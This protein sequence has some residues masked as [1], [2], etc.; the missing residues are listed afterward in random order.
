[1]NNKHR[2]SATPDWHFSIPIG[3]INVKFGAEIQLSL[4]YFFFFP[5][6]LPNLWGMLGLGLW[7]A[8]CYEIAWLDHKLR[9]DLPF[10]VRIYHSL[11]CW[12]NQW[13]TAPT[14]IFYSSKSKLLQAFI[15]EFLSVANERTPH[16]LYSISSVLGRIRCRTVKEV[17][18]VGN[19]ASYYLIQGYHPNRL[20]IH[21]LLQIF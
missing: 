11:L 13:F 2:L 18:M 7:S 12:T 6:T 9:Q 19:L 16:F 1:M 4:R 15:L 3:F 17:A 8:T 5:S 14:T 20:F 10:Y 21:Q